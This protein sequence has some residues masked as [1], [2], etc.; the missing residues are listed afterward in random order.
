[1]T[2]QRIVLVEVERKLSDSI[3]IHTHIYMHIHAHIFIHIDIDTD[4]SFEGCQSQICCD[5]E[6]RKALNKV[7]NRK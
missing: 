7:N 4:F 5:L 2:S 1:M 6:V 3:Y